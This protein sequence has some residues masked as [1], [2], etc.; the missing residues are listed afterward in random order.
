LGEVARSTAHLIVLD[1][2]TLRGTS[3]AGQSHGLQLLA[4]YLPAERWML[5]QVAVGRKENEITVAPKVLE[6]LDLRGKVTTGDAMLAQRDLSVQVV[7]AGGDYVWVVKENQPELCQEIETLFRPGH[8]VKGFG[9]GTKDF[10]TAKTTEKGHGRLECRQL[11]LS[12]E[13]KGY[14]NWLA[15]DQVFKLERRFIR[16]ADGRVSEETVY[17]I[18]GLTA[19][20]AGPERL[21]RLIRGH[22]VIENGLHYRRDATLR[23]DWCRLRRGHAPVLAKNLIRSRIT[24][25][26]TAC[27][28][29]R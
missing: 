8:I 3:R 19:A 21:L 23:E 4:A 28:I 15:A 5:M 24:S 14:L 18:T 1:G 9:A 2:K 22:R 11:T 27:T 6:C 10:R 16:S 7:D 26:R 29:S 20:E 17:G 13:L 25:N 12:V